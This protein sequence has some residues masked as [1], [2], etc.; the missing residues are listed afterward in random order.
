VLL[1]YPS[2]A[3]RSIGDTRN[4]LWNESY[5]LYLQDDWKAT[6]RLTMNLGVRYDFETPF[7]SAD[8]RLVRFNPDNGNIEIAGNPSTRRDIGRVDNPASPTYNAQLAKLDEGLTIVN[9]GRRNIYFFDHGRVVPRIGL[10]YRML[11]N[12]RLVLRT[13]YGIFINQLLG[14]FGQAGWNT[15]PFFISQTFN[16]AAG[17]PNI[18]IDN[19]YP[20][21][22]AGAT[23]N[24]AS[25]TL[26]SRTG[27]V[28]NWNFGFQL[29]PWNDV[30][31]DLTY[32]GSASTKLVAS[33][34]IN[35]PRPSLVGSVASRRPYQGF[36]NISYQD[37]VSSANF[38]SLQARVEKRYSNG[39]TVAGAY[40]FSK[41]LDTTGSGDGDSGPPDAYNIRGT[42]YGPSTFDAKHR[43]VTSYVYDLPFGADKKYLAGFSGFARWA[44]SGW[45]IS[46]INTDEA[47]R[48]FTVSITADNSNTGAS[49]TDRPNLIGNPYL[50][51]GQ[52]SAEQWFNPAAF[53]LPPKGTQGN[54]GR[55]TM[56]GPP[57]NQTD[58]SLIKNSQFGENKRVQFRAEV[59]NILNH[60]N[61]DLPSRFID[62]STVGGIFRAEA[63]RQIQL[64][65]KIIY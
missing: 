35:Q 6:S 22:L 52:R 7:R 47:G 19:P 31:V 61:L 9:V 55:N 50:P 45:E 17:T 56:T 38:N 39:F 65:L 13:G 40:T 18:T 58:F 15:F 41:S 23:L 14:Q 11:G 62:A 42:M 20:A 49:Q 21:A 27:Y 8:D 32:T 36:G 59:F 12:D 34:N 48:P 3:K 4:P 2:I 54:L 10:A 26:H 53:A 46:G 44:V 30:L 43:L 64:G 28:Q 5:G 63:S 57:F 51:R 37:S 1:G 29:Q 25:V 33:R 16:G 60:P 24:P